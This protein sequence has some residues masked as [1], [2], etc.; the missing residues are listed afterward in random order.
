MKTVKQKIQL[1]ENAFSALYV[2]DNISWSHYREQLFQ[3]ALEGEK[4]HRGSNF[5]HPNAA[6]ATVCAKMFAVRWLA[7]HLTKSDKMPKVKDF[8]S[9]R[10]ECYIAAALVLNYRKEIRKALKPYDLNELAAFDYVE[11]VGA[12]S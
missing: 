8:L 1:V 7:G 12:A 10:R 9:V 4:Q 2:L 5:G 11:F 6:S 3:A